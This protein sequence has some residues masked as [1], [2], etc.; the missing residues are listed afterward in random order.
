MIRRPRLS[1]TGVR[2]RLAPG[3]G[4]LLLLSAC[5]D[6]RDARSSASSIGT[7]VSGTD[8]ATGTTT[9]S[10]TQG[11][12]NEGH[13]SEGST[14]FS[15]TSAT[16]DASGTHGSTG[17][18]GTDDTTDD[19]TTG[20]FCHFECSL[21]LQTVLCDGEPYQ[22]CMGTEGCNAQINACSDG[23]EVAAHNKQ[24]IGCE[25][26]A[27][28]MQ[29][30]SPQYCFAAFVANTW[31]DNA[32][33]SVERGGAVLQ[34]ETFARLPVGNGPGLT[35][36]AYDPV[37]GLAPGEV[38]ILFL[39]GTSGNTPNCP[40]A[41]AVI[42]DAGFSGTGVS[43]AFRI[44]TDVPVVAYQINPYGG[45]SV[46]VTGASLLLP[47][48]V[49]DD[50]YVAVNIS[51]QDIAPPSMNII[52][53]E[54]DTTVT[55]TPIANVVGGGGIPAGQAG[56]PLA[57]TLAAGQYAQITQ[58]AELTGS[59][60]TADKPI[61]HLAGQPCMRAP[62]GVA[63]C[64]HGE[65]MIPPVNA[66]GSE[67][68]G[69]MHRPR[70]GEPGI[71]RM[72][73]AV[74][75]TQLSWNVDVGGPATLQLGQ[76]VEFITPTPFVVSSQDEDHPFLLFNYMSGSQWNQLSNTTGHG[77]PD[78]V[79][80]IS[81]EQYMNRYVFFADPTYPEGNL[82]I[83]RKRTGGV[84]HDVELDCAGVVG[85]WQAVGDYE[86]T[87]VDLI[88]GNFQNVGN[89]SSGRREMWSDGLFGL[90]NWGWGTPLT[91]TFTSNVSY[92]Y[93]AGLRV[94]PINQVILPQ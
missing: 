31:H 54:N 89:C 78:A 9:D 69:V 5:G 23:C 85:G 80:S 45:G 82:V 62:H 74:D 22:Q 73:G 84:F 94:E 49:W 81:T 56:Q 24:S 68:V 21:D 17:T 3:L 61:G 86:W 39:S 15:S 75:G 57:F 91:S 1:V 27:V 83:V 70:A 48:S 36:Q 8:G 67:Y 11:D 77:D 50:S 72:I 7:S 37:A 64:D 88:T 10:T 30:T 19:A 41:P 29:S 35:Y 13:G 12:G 71:W 76:I 60:L 40:V 28:D 2:G 59:V 65:Q 25:Y 66:L 16:D 6:E 90:W 38:A 58:S 43:D 4:V 47:T 92:G 63:Y 32:H 44:S 42:G 52:A 87:R 34:V 93:P 53:M 51:A 55:L 18:T 26:Y 79:L 14:G 20:P 46:A 33:I